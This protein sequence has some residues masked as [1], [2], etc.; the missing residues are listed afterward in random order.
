MQLPTEQMLYGKQIQPELVDAV[1]FSR[2]H[3]IPTLLLLLKISFEASIHW[4]CVGD[5]AASKAIL[6]MFNEDI[7]LFYGLASS[8]NRWR[9]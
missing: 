2:G 3:P 5:A 9:L 1:G 7:A 4:G 8:P 6:R